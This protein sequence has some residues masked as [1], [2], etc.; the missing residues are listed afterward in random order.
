MQPWHYSA[1]S[2]RPT[3]RARIETRIGFDVDGVELAAPGQP[4]GRGLKHIK[5]PKS[6]QHQNRST[7]PSN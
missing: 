6:N 5:T 1:R 2:A 7:R 4:A 3:S